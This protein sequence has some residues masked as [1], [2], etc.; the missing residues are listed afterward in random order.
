VTNFCNKKTLSSAFKLNLVYT[1]IFTNSK[2]DILSFELLKYSN[3][4]AKRGA[5]CPIGYVAGQAGKY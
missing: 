2:I 5:H 3:T 4:A 1:E